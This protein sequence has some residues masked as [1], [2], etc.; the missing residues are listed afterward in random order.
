ML[1]SSQWRTSVSL[2]FAVRP[3]CTG[4][5]AA[6]PS[7][8]GPFPE[9]RG[10]LAERLEDEETPVL[11][12][13]GSAGSGRGALARGVARSLPGPPLVLTADLVHDREGR[14]LLQWLGG[15]GGAGEPS[16]EAGLDA[17]VE[18]LGEERRV[19][20]RAPIV[21]LDGVAAG[22]PSTAWV[23][24][25][26]GAA[27]WS[28]AFKLVLTGA[29]GIPELLARAGADL[30]GAT[31]PELAVPRLPREDVGPHVRGWIDA[32]LAPGAP[33][34][35]VSPDALLLLALRADGELERLDGIAENMLVLAAAERRR[36]LGSWEAWAAS[37][38]ERWCDAPG[39]LALP[40]RPGRWPPPDVIDVIDACRRG[41]GLSPWPRRSE[42]PP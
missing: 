8:G 13:T 32:A 9:L 42:E 23:A 1:P 11:A 15:A 21:V 30:R 12:V 4:A 3:F 19:R 35:V 38:G 28:R 6:G 29:P 25:L 16:G 2:G 14:T 39:P 41:A 7:P 40:R 17:L 24:V 34:I 37:D 5:P 36:T 33:P 27:L 20:G 10:R 18:R 26:A 22:Q 31:V